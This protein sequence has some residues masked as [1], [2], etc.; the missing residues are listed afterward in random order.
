MMEGVNCCLHYTVFPS[1]AQKSLIHINCMYKLQFEQLNPIQLMTIIQ[2]DTQNHE[3]TIHHDL[4]K[5]THS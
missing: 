3:C 1:I 5:I 4:S 2:N